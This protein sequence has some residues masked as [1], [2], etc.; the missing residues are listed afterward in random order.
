VQAAGDG[1]LAVTRL[2]AARIGDLA[3]ER[4]LRLHEL[5]PQ[6]ASLEQAFMELT[7]DSVEYAA[8]GGARAGDR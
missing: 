5:A 2:P 6:R 3:A 7:H 8:T 4:G 1:A